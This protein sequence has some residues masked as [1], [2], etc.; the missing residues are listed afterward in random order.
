M[1]RYWICAMTLAALAANTG[2]ASPRPALQSGVDLQYVDRSV[3]PQDDLY[4]YLNGKWLD[5]FQL[6]A[7]KGIYVSFTQVDDTTQE[8]LRAIVEGL[9]GN[10]P[11]TSAADPD[12]R[13]LSDFYASFMDEPRLEALGL[14]P[15]R[16]EFAA[17]DAMSDKNQIPAAIAHMNRIGAGAP[18]DFGIGQDARN[19]TQYAV[20]VH[21]SGLGMPDRDY[22][23]KDDA[24][25][26]ETRAK[27]LA[28]VAKMLG[29]AGDAQSGGGRRGRSRT[30]NRAGAGAVDPGREPRPGEDV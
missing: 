25:L 5:N 14:E 1:L 10:V 19:S 20:I 30:R 4:R 22:Y 12:I 29:M 16:T 3:R 18:F 8:Q 24:K 21:Q 23:L 17:I 2:G 6:P 28:H 13:K 27:Y 15:L 7:D 9:A 26:K 11:G